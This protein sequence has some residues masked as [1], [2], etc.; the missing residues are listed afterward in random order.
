MTT[1]RNERWTLAAWK[2]GSGHVKTY[3]A[4]RVCAWPTCKVRL[5]VY[6][7]DATCYAHRPEPSLY[8]CGHRFRICA[9][10]GSVIENRARGECRACRS[11][12]AT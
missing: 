6:N 9:G 2:P 5:S 11:K 12:Q 3:P 4:G 10:C 8:Y 7:P 1:P